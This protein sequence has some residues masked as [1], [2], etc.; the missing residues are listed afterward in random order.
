MGK[1]STL[2]YICPSHYAPHPNKKFT[3]THTHTHTQQTRDV[4]VY[5]PSSYVSILKNHPV[6]YF[7][8]TMS[9]G[10]FNWGLNPVGVCLCVCVCVCVYACLIVPR[11]LPS[12][13]YDVYFSDTHTHIHTHTHTHTPTG[14]ATRTEENPPLPS[15]HCGH[16]RCDTAAAHF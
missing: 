5:D 3:H 12:P 16:A 6:E 4:A 15:Q 11:N 9:Y 7:D 1:R 2:L 14:H 10:V 8:N 13:I